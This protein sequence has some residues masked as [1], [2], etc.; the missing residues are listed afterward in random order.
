MR[1]GYDGIFSTIEKIYQGLGP[2]ARG[3]NK[4]AID[5]DEVS[6]YAMKHA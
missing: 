5:K 4:K 6:Y 3:G 2:D 1:A